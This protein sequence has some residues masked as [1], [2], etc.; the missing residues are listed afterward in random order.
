M[1]SIRPLLRAD[2]DAAVELLMTTSA[3]DIRHRLRDRLTTADPDHVNYALVAEQNGA[4]AG[5][6]KLTTEP[7]FPG[8]VSALVAPAIPRKQPVRFLRYGPG[9]GRCT[10]RGRCRVEA[11][12]PAVSQRRGDG[13]SSGAPPV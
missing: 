4:M 3:L 8:T 1:Y 6:A 5:V 2:L 12:F 13:L 7:A 9:S 10:G 11:A